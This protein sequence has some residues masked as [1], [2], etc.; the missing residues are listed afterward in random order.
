MAIFA[1]RL[2]P[3]PLAA[4]EASVV[5]FLANPEATRIRHALA[6]RR[7]LYRELPFLYRVPRGIKDKKGTVEDLGFVRGQ[8]DLLYQ[9]ESGEWTLID[10]KTGVQK[11]AEHFRQAQLYAFCLGRLLGAPV[12]RARMYYTET[13]EFVDVPLKLLSD[14]AFEKDLTTTFERLCAQVLGKV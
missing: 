6:A 9:D 4:L 3:E 11:P 12:D 10:Y 2:G 7:G 1:L 14:P 8:V 5:R 13:G